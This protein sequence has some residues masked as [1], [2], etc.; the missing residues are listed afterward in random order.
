MKFEFNLT[1]QDTQ[2]AA[3]RG[4]F[5]TPRGIVQTPVFMPVGTF[6]AV[7]TLD[8]RD[9]KELDAEIILANTYHLMIRPGQA[10][11]EK[12]GGIHRFTGWNK[13]LLTDSGGFQIFNLPDYR[14]ITEEGAVFRSYV[15]GQKF[16]L[17]PEKSIEMQGAIGSDIMMVLDQCIESTAD[18]AQTRTAMELTH[19]WALRSLAA[20]KRQ[21]QALFGIIQGGVF[22]DL[23]HAS[24]DFLTQHPFDGF[25][26]GGLAVGETKSQRED[27]TELVASRL[28]VNKP[29]YLMGVGTPID[30]LEAV[31]RGVDMFDCI[32]PTM[33]AQRGA[34]F[35]TQGKINLLATALRLTDTPLDPDCACSTCAHYSLGYLHH[36]SKCKEPTGW[37]LVSIHNQ[38]YYT[39]LMN[40]MREAIEQNR[41]EAFYRE[42]KAKI[43]PKTT[44]ESTVPISLPEA[45]LS[46]SL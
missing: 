41:F 1:H 40:Q 19:R 45:A 13:P 33:F 23:R 8:L 27:F 4:W 12:F 44:L 30:L 2:T 10:V 38:F 6:A 29:R 9:L 39:K 7:K 17:S 26:I 18:Y 15:D 3:R 32:I 21:D 11:F 25:A 46:P 34:V 5:R 14:L 36:L 24:V 42:T 16:L 43:S 35:T 20:R 37:R 31:R 22:E 28:P